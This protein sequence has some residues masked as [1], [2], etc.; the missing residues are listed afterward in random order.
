MLAEDARARHGRRPARRARGRLGN[1]ARGSSTCRRSSWRSCAPRSRSCARA[2]A[3]CPR[4]RS[5]RRSTRVSGARPRASG[6]RC[7][8]SR[9]AWASRSC[10]RRGSVGREHVVDAVPGGLEPLREEGFAAYARRVSE[11]YRAAMAG[12]FDPERET[13]TERALARLRA[14]KF[15]TLLSGSAS[16]LCGVKRLLVGLAALAALGAA[17]PAQA[18]I[19]MPWCGTDSSAVDRLPD[20]TLG[21]AV[22]VVYVRA[23]GGA[24]RFGELAP[25]IVGDVAAIEAWWRSQD[26]TRAPRFDLFPIACATAFGALDITNVE[27]PQPVSGVTARS[28]R[29]G[30]SS[31]RRLQRARED[32]SRLLR[33][34]DRPDRPRADL[35]PG[36]AAERP[37]PGMAI[38][39]LDSCGATDSD[40][41]RPVVGDP[42]ARPRPRRRQRRRAHTAAAPATSA[43]SSP[44]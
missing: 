21:Y 3:S 11:P 17:A 37:A 4:R 31:R 41:L 19:P 30:C 18:S 6:G 29:S 39:Y 42:R 24:D 28:T 26:A 15:S 9:P 1:D 10:S 32:L 27:L 44:T 43:T 20:A 13:W 35:R 38:V 5:W 36:R 16:T 8:R 2:R 23:P 14:L 34:A 33:R 7:S 12:H 25:R 22:H 40:S